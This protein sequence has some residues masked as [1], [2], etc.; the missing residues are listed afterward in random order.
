MS[1]T[2]PAGLQTALE[3][4]VTTLCRL[5]TVTSMTGTV[6]RFTDNDRDVFVD[7]NTFT[8]SDSFSASAIQMTADVA[9]AQSVSITAVM[10]GSGFDETDLR[11]GK[12][13]GAR[14][15]VQ[16]C[17]YTD[18][19]LG[20]FT[21]YAGTFGDMDLSDANRMTVD[22]LPL[23]AG[24][25]RTVSMERYGTS[26]RWTLGDDGCG[27]D[28]EA[29]KVAFTVDSVPATDTFAA[30]ELS[31][32][33]EH[34]TLG[35]VKWITGDNAGT[36]TVVRSSDQSSTTVSLTGIPLKAIQVGDTGEVYP[37]CDKQAIMCRDEFDNI[38]RRRA[39]DFV[40]T[41]LAMDTVLSHHLSG[42]GPG[43]SAY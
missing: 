25:N 30:S 34:W 23:S 18:P 39:E 40:P 12:W 5:W 15:V 24:A 7:P 3:Q 29:L 33:D 28:I 31:Q 41:E 16:I 42:D 8:A 19:T 4:E 37:G 11:Q 6:L 13:K 10:G 38:P 20:V 26:C 32:A 2:I 22:L 17:D 36:F 35:M 14:A 1:R 43:G 27:V 9:T 21:I